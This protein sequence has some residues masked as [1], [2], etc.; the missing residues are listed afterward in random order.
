MGGLKPEGVRVGSSIIAYIGGSVMDCCQ[1]C[2]DPV[3][4]GMLRCKRCSDELPLP[5][6]G[7]VVI[8]QD[9]GCDF[10]PSCLHCPFMVCVYERSRS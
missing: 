3:S 8:Q 9:R 6:E 7:L 2:G 5:V 1:D 10:A 4:D